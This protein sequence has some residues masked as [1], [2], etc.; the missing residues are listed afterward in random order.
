MLLSQDQA[1]KVLPDSKLLTVQRV[2]NGYIISTTDG[3][4]NVVEDGNEASMIQGMQKYFCF[5]AVDFGETKEEGGAEQL[6][7]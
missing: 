5:I 2:A 6:E 7:V 4:I 1:A 3:A